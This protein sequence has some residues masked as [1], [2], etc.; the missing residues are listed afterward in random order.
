MCERCEQVRH[1]TDIV[2]QVSCQGWDLYDVAQM[3]AYL[4]QG[5][6]LQS[7]KMNEEKE[8]LEHWDRICKHEFMELNFKHPQEPKEFDAKY[9]F[10]EHIKGE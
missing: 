4:F 3:A 2:M 6:R 5:L 9:D 7:I 10:R 8:F 1:V